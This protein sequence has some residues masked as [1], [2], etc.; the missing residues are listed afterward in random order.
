MTEQQLISEL[1]GKFYSF[2]HDPFG[3]TKVK[4]KQVP[5]DYMPSHSFSTDEM[6]ERSRRGAYCRKEQQARRA[7]LIWTPQRLE[8]LKAYRK[9]GYGSKRIQ[10]LMGISRGFIEGEI[11]RSG[12]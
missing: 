1:T 8:A 4:V 7:K 2:T 5:A 9:L 12:L 10:K 6:L 3:D 11:K